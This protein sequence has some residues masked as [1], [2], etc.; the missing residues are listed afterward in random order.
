MRSTWFCMFV[1][2]TV[3]LKYELKVENQRELSTVHQRV[4]G[5]GV[6]KTTPNKIESLYL[7]Q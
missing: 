5:C 1:A 6:E 3:M 7:R 4:G 2:S